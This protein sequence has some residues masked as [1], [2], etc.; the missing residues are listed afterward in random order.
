MYYSAFQE[1]DYFMPYIRWRTAERGMRRVQM[2]PAFG[3]IL[4]NLNIICILQ[5]AALIVKVFHVLIGI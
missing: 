4:A 1:H 5:T 3:F 2:V